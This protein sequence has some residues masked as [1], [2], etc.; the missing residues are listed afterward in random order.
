MAFEEITARYK[1][2][3]FRTLSWNEYEKVLQ[4]LLTKIQQQLQ[5]NNQKIDIIVPILRGGSFPGTYLAYKLNILRVVPVQYKYFYEDGKIELRQLLELPNTIKLPEK[6]VILLVENNHCFGLTASTAAKDIKERFPQATIIYA[7]D[8]MDY[9]YQENKYAD[10]VIYGALNNDTKTLSD[11]E[12]HAQG[13]ETTSNIFP[14]EVEE[15]EWTTI[16]AKQ[17]TY[18]D[19]QEAKINSEFKVEL[20]EE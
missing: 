20:N 4:I 11:S 18:A 13:F 15:E 1:K 19:T 7:A 10:V 9:S 5:Q 16:E 2:D 6:P 12:A 8:Y 17:F 14:W 3:G